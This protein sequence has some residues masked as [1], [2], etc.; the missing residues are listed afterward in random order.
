MEEVAG[1]IPARSTKY[2]NNLRKANA[3]SRGICVMNN[4]MPRHLV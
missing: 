4:F 1:S 2:L 3:R